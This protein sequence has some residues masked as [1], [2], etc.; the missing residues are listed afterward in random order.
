MTTPGLYVHIQDKLLTSNIYVRFF[1]EYEGEDM[2]PLP[3]V[4]AD[5]EHIPI[6]QDES[7]FHTNEYRHR[8]WT[9][10]GQQPL[11][12]KGN[13]RAIHVSDFITEQG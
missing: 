2:E 13:G 1:H 5:K 7:T 4:F 10:V 11:R 12:K 6:Y 3:A 8:I 9:K